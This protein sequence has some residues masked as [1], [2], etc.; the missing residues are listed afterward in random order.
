M[1]FVT[2][3]EIKDTL[4]LVE[5]FWTNPIKTSK[6]KHIINQRQNTIKRLKIYLFDQIFHSVSKKANITPAVRIFIS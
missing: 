5:K 6:Q 3:R 4:V 2:L 1:I